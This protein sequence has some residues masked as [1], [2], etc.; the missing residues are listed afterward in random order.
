MHE[1]QIVGA[2]EECA[3]PDIGIDAIDVRIDTGAKTSSLHAD[4][5][6]EFT[7]GDQPWIRYEIHP[8]IHNVDEVVKCES[9]I[10]RKP[11]IKSSNGQSERR[12]LIRTTL[13]LGGRPWAIDLTL[14]DRAL[15]KYQMLL[16][17]QGMG[18][19]ILVDPSRNFL[20]SRG[21]SHKTQ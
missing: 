14:T 12:Y 20:V 16:G 10:E 1:K 7:K 11:R 8:N 3:L 13:V 21:S 6:E 18:D 9:K 15:M 4:N 5:L 2:V 17:R 19:K